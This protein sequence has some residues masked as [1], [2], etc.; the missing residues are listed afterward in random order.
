M[1][2]W[3]VV[4][5]L[6]DSASPSTSFLDQMAAWDKGAEYCDA[7]EAPHKVVHSPSGKDPAI[8]AFDKNPKQEVCKSRVYLFA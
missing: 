4:S 6:P 5:P 3:N 1:W 7:V 8:M 2:K